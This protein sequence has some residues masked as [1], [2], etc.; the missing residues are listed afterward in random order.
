[1]GCEW[2]FRGRAKR[3]IE[4]DHEGAGGGELEVG[5]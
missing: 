2:S 4:Y 3:E 5:V 1:M